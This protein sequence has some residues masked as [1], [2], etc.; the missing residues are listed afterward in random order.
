MLF[1]LEFDP[2]F[3]KDFSK[4]QWGYFQIQG[5]NILQMQAAGDIKRP[6]W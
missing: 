5:I 2:V 3:F 6:R 4:Q 1:V